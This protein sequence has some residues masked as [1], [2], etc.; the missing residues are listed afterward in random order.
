M[1]VSCECS[2]CD[3][4]C[5]YTF[6]ERVLCTLM[7]LTFNIRCSALILYQRMIPSLCK[8]KGSEDITTT[9]FLFFFSFLCDSN[10]VAALC[11]G[12]QLVAWKNKDWYSSNVI[13]RGM[14]RTKEIFK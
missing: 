1:N 8:Y 9:L 11:D 14:K 10:F 3:I 12:F 2:Q 5:D 6:M 7:E 13:I 4:L